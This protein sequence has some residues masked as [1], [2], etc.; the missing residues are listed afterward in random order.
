MA[1][2]THPV[3]Y[4]YITDDDVLICGINISLTVKK[5]K[6]RRRLVLQ[7]SNFGYNELELLLAH[8]IVI[9]ETK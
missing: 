7:V 4:I 1:I 8:V 2:L 3:Q 5:K 6:N 9:F